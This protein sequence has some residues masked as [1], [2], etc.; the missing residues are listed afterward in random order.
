MQLT[1]RYLLKN[2][3]VIVTNDAGFVTEYRQVYQKNL[4]VYRGIDNVLEFQIKNADQKPV[5]ITGNTVKFQS[6]DENRNLII[7]H[8]A[9]V[10]DATKGLCKVTVTENDLLNVKR[11]F[12]SYNIHM[13]D[14]NGDKIL[15]YVD[16][17]FGNTGTIEVANDAFPGPREPHDVRTFTEIEDDTWY[18]ESI[19]AQP[20]INGNEALHTAVFYTDSF[21][22]NITVQATLHNQIIQGVDWCDIGTIEFDGTETEPVPYNF[23]GVYSHIRFKSDAD[24]AQTISKIL[25]KN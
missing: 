24:P 17:H 19:D 12:L 3:T 9:V 5:N 10:L 23:N 8:D 25:I 4:K 13:V 21:T 14:S 2:R 15:T 11:Q 18:S 20:G 7:Q 6:Y 1:P 22:G 16:E